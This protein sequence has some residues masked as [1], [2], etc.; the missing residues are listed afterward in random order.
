MTALTRPMTTQ[1]REFELVPTLT[2]GYYRV[3]K[4]G[5]RFVVAI[6]SK[7]I[8]YD[9]GQFVGRIVGENAGD[10][11]RFS[12]IDVHYNEKDLNGCVLA[13]SLREV[14]EENEIPYREVVSRGF[15]FRRFGDGVQK[16]QGI[17]KRLGVK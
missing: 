5:P 3:A 6:K 8:L 12:G 11:S 16:L 1:R 7:D 2:A 10:G 9:G 15:D 17:A 14:C 13:D 4:T